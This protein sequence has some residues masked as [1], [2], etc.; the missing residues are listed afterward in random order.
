MQRRGA[1]QRVQIP[2]VP[3]EASRYQ[4]RSFSKLS[5]RG[6]LVFRRRGGGVR[7][8]WPGRSASTRRRSEGKGCPSASDVRAQA[9]S[10]TWSEV[11]GSVRS[12]QLAGFWCHLAAAARSVSVPAS[13]GL[14]CRW[15]ARPFLFLLVSPQHRLPQD[16]LFLLN[17]PCLIPKST[18]LHL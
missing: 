12:G 13:E 15:A 7:K 10:R 4:F 1:G 2:R 17:S 5:T 8:T 6:I 16:R 11:E 14:D 9:K 3:R 18:V